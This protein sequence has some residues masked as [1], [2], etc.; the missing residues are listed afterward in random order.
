MQHSIWDKD[1]KNPFDNEE[2]S[3]DHGRNLKAHPQSTFHCPRELQ[4]PCSL[5]WDTSRD[6]ESTAF[7]GTL[8]RCSTCRKVGHRATSRNEARTAP[9]PFSLG[10]VLPDLWRTQLV[11]TLILP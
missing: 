1:W 4:T 5:A 9:N 6:R 11:E 10:K 2:K 3:Q 7:L 8:L